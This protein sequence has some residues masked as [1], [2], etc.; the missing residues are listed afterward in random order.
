MSDNEE[1]TGNSAS[2]EQIPI[3]VKVSVKTRDIIDH[4]KKE[5]KTISYIIEEAI[6]RYAS[7][8][9][10]SPDI[11]AML[12]KHIETYGNERTVLEKAIKLLDA[13]EDLRNSE[14][15]DLWCKARDELKMMLIGKTTF[16]QMLEAAEAPEQSLDK[17][18]KKNIALDVI[19]WYVKKPLNQVDLEE[20]LAAIRRIWIMANYFYSIDVEGGPN[21]FHLIFKHHQ[22]RRYSNYWL[23]Y[24]KEM[25]RSQDLSFKCDVEG[26]ALDETLSLT[27]RKT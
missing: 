24:F 15:I 14:D 13:E 9:S 5:G 7:F 3:Y 27:I 19:L 21:E 18:M 8:K 11:V 2:Q 25:F 12:N 22:N 4:Y 23:G 10:L 26:Q 1:K 17:P 20:I 16:S 6:K